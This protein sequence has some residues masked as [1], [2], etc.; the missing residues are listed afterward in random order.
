[1]CLGLASR[2]PQVQ[3]PQYPGGRAK[4]RVGPR[5]VS[6]VWLARRPGSTCFLM[7]G[8]IGLARARPTTSPRSGRN[9]RPRT[10]L[11]PAPAHASLPR[12]GVRG[13]PHSVQYTTLGSNGANGIYQG[14]RSRQGGCPGDFAPVTTNFQRLDP[15]LMRQAAT[16]P[17]N[18]PD[19]WS[20]RGLSASIT[21]PAWTN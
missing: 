8:P 20:A 15:D 17:M 10:Y 14:G 5:T 4:V 1:M 12:S 18:Y 7:S 21:K 2:C 3:F 11:I 16:V 6:N 13:L 19:L 9:H